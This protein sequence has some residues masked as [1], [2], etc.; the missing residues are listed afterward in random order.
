MTDRC[1]FCEK[2]IGLLEEYYVV[3]EQWRS[4]GKWMNVGVCCVACLGEGESIRS[5]RTRT[6]LKGSKHA[7][8]G[9]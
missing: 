5:L 3:Q 7:N 2:E 8:R 6:W 4:H 1:K 9:V